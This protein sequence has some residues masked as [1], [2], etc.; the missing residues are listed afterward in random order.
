MDK[1]TMNLI[2][3]GS[4]GH[5]G[6][7]INAVNRRGQHRIIGLL[8]EMNPVG[9]IRHGYRIEDLNKDWSHAF[10]FIAIGDNAARERLST[11]PY[12]FVNIFH[13]SACVDV[14]C[15]GSY[16]G[17]NSVVG[18]GSIVGNF[19]II[20]TGVILEHD[21]SVGNFSHLCP[22]VVTG[23]RV[24]IGS[25]TTIGLGAMIRDGVTI[26]D[27]C[28]IGMGSVVLKNVPDNSIAWGNP[29]K[30]QRL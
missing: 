8:D 15:I 16:F 5:A 17:A 29:C 13:P 2:I 28:T 27:N 24:K 22:G 21:S 25:G 1:E 4:S 23:G 6:V 19:S 10:A 14:D 9:E 3:F 12:K 26:G 7:V 18:N 30:L 20:N 11:K